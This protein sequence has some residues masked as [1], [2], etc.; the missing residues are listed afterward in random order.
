[1]VP[2]TDVMALVAPTTPPMICVN[3]L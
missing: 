3:G 2:I 1:M